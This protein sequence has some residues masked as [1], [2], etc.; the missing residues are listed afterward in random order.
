[1]PVVRIQTNVRK[2]G[3]TYVARKKLACRNCRRHSFNRFYIDYLFLF[4][5]FDV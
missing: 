3:S 1:M 2:Y 5:H 4:V